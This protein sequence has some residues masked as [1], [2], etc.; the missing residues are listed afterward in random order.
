MNNREE[1]K[2]MEEDKEYS[3]FTEAEARQIWN[4]AKTQ[5]EKFPI[6]SLLVAGF[7][8]VELLQITIGDSHIQPE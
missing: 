2:R 7:R 6:S 1:P 5:Q 3:Y 4:A 8:L